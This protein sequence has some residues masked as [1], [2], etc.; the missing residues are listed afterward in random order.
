MKKT[1]ILALLPVFLFSIIGWQWMF[2][3]RLYSHQEKEWTAFFNEEELEI[4]A[5]SSNDLKNHDS[6]L[7]NDHELYH[8]GKYFD[9]KFKKTTGNQIV[10]YCHADKE[11]SGLYSGLDSHLKDEAGLS[12]TSKQKSVKVVK[13]SV[14]EKVQDT[15]FF[16]PEK[17]HQ[18]VLASNTPLRSF[19]LGNPVFVP[20][21]AGA[22]IS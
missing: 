18:S 7:V 15:I 16:G 19:F 9:I 6:F 20:P 2:A 12:N 5:V 22:L 17:I 21:D 8:H 4:I 14:F 1:I 11:E 13:L 3:L 10:F